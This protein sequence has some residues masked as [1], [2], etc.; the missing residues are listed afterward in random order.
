MALL[1]AKFD[2]VG[3]VEAVEVAANSYIHQYPDDGPFMIC[4]IVVAFRAAYVASGGG[5]KENALGIT[6]ATH[7]G[8]ASKS[9]TTDTWSVTKCKRSQAVLNTY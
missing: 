2:V 1:T 7:N 5:R 6:G 3:F 8:E 9:E 4:A